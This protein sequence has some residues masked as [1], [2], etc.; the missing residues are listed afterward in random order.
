[1]NTDVK[2]FIFNQGTREESV[3]E[4]LLETSDYEPINALAPRLW[5]TL[6]GARAKSDEIDIGNP[7]KNKTPFRKGQ[8][9]LMT[10]FLS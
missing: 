4:L 1:M 2:A 6:T 8:V 9:S 10:Y 7:K 3:F 5:L